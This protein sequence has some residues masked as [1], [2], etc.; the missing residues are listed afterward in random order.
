LVAGCCHLQVG[1]SLLLLPG[2]T[3]DVH[4]ASSLFVYNSIPCAYVVCRFSLEPIDLR[5][6][7]FETR[8]NS[9]LALLGKRRIA[10]QLFG[11]V[12]LS[13]FCACPALS[14][15]WWNH[16]AGISSLLPVWR[17]GLGIAAPLLP[18]WCA[19]GDGRPVWCMPSGGP[20][21]RT[22]PP[23]PAWRIALLARRSALVM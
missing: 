9:P 13:H 17:Q 14:C 22:K 8:P 15:M 7:L 19:S 5:R 1:W 6:L 12:P 16:R 2:S 11:I 20:A 3:R 23:T 10:L 4:G 18:A 21:P